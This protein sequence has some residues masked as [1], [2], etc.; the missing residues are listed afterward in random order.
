MSPWRK[1]GVKNY[2]LGYWQRTDI[3]L[4]GCLLWH[5]SHSH[6][7]LQTSYA[8]SWI[9]TSNSILR[10]ENKFQN[11]WPP[12]TCCELLLSFSK[13]GRRAWFVSSQPQHSY[14]EEEESSFVLEDKHNESRTQTALSCS[15]IC[16]IMNII[17]LL[18]CLIKFSS[19]CTLWVIYVPIFFVCF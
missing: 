18:S 9:L 5:S 17:W 11:H 14:M 3:E 10:E 8:R 12:L 16:C 13:V 1:A 6:S 15:F 19:K 2:S 7:F 4:E